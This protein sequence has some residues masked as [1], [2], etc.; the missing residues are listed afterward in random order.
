M[1]WLPSERYLSAMES[2]TARVAAAVTGRDP[3]EQVPTCPEWTLRDLVTHIGTGHRLSAAVVSAK[4]D[5][6]RPYQL[7]EAPE[8]PALWSAWLIE[9]ADG[10]VG[11]VR[12]QGFD[13]PVWT[14]APQ[15]QTT[16][17]WV[18]RMLHDLIIHRFDAEPGDDLDQDLAVDGVADILLCYA[19]L[20][21][22]EGTPMAAGL[23]GD[24]ETLR[25]TDGSSVWRATLTP[26]GVTWHDSDGPAD[27]ELRAPAQELLLVLNRR[28][29]PGESTGDRALLDRW[30][31]T[32]KF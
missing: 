30:L 3:A 19:T 1:N 31:A 24:G 11:A 25:F 2:E 7:I 28:R 16:G 15:H 21:R 22:R 27:V 29:P 26:D 5:E 12:E 17:F 4:L 6:P 9:G 20:S 13:A 14:W 23:R 10:L 32:T 8:K 18:R